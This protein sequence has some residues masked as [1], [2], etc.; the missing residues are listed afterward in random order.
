[1]LCTTSADAITC[2][3]VR[4]TCSSLLPLLAKLN[5]VH[6][7]AIKNRAPLILCPVFFHQWFN[8]HIR[9]SVSAIAIG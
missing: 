7:A 8:R 3:V 4:E 5:Q 6:H 9:R 2:T 1:M